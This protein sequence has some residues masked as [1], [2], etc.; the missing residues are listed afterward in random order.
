MSKSGCEKVIR[1]LKSPNVNRQFLHRNC[2]HFGI[3]QA[4]LLQQRDPDKSFHIDQYTN[5]VLQEIAEK[6]RKY[7]I[8]VLHTWAKPEQEIFFQVQSAHYLSA[9]LQRSS[10]SLPPYV[11]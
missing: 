2:S 4:I 10:I 3:F 8:K 7:K 5:Y 1:A 6:L 9:A 11:Y